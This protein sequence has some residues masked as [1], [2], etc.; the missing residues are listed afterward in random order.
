MTY[1]S[2]S[3]AISKRS[4][5]QTH[6]R[7]RSMLLAALLLGAGS[8]FAA[9]P[10]SDAGRMQF[11][12]GDVRIVSADQ[13]S[14]QAA[15]GDVVREGDR[16]STGTRANA[17]IVMSDGGIIA[18]RPGSDLV[19]QQFRYAGRDDGS[20]SSILSLIKGGFRTI[21]GVIGR[22]NRDNYQVN[23]ATATIGIRGTDHE[24][25]YVPTPGVGET[26]IGE[27]GTYNR[28]NS[29]ETFIRTDQGTSFVGPNQV[30][31]AGLK[32]APQILKTPP[33][34]LLRSVPLPQGRIDIRQERARLETALDD[35]R[36]ALVTLRQ[37]TDLLRVEK[38]VAL[39]QQY[40]ADAADCTIVQGPA[41]AAAASNLVA[42][43]AQTAIVGGDLSSGPSFGNGAALIDGSASVGVATTEGV[44]V[45]LSDR[46][47]FRFGSVD[48]T[49]VDFGSASANGTGLRWGIYA[50][51]VIFSPESGAR[52]PTNFHYMMAANYS[53]IADLTVPGS[54]VMTTTVGYTRPIDEQGR[55]G[56]SAALSV[57]L[58]YGALPR[59]QA[60]NLSVVDAGGRNWS[61]NLV[62]PQTLASFLTSSS[63]PNLS[64][65]CSGACAT[66]GGGHAAGIVAG[67]AN[68][69]V[70]ISS[71]TLKAGTA[72]VI[73]SVAVKQ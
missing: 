26:P 30:A 64:V 42:V 66:S 48:A 24:V 9:S 58:I 69:D 53:T 47:G 39:R 71:Y 49:L 8:A 44:L 16:I 52:V 65:T 13:R 38:I 50:G 56:G 4:R 63:T 11:A 35:A 57:G 21:T 15:K 27:P 17:Q 34:F 59:V 55:I 23:T 33:A 10:S 41:A 20:E 31:F 36:D 73:G 12:A 51:G 68:R 6:R 28:V 7:S 60:Y 54:A 3:D 14:R 32:Q 43:P 70:F 25:Y 62:S 2:R 72:G 40:C 45:L 46:T 18:L 5:V 1:H 19:I 22:R 67:G 29:G 37:R 61:A